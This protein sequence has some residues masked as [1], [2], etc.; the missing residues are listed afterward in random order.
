MVGGGDVGSDYY[1]GV[2][3]W[4][5]IGDVGSDYYG[6]VEGWSEIQ[7]ESVV[8]LHMPDTK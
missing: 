4:S 2:E 7:I 1:G 8:K 5:E 6:G 3:G